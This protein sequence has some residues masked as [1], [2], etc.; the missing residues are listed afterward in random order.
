VNV[1]PAQW[2]YALACAALCASA[3]SACA[4]TAPATDAVVALA[5]PPP[6]PD[7]RVVPRTPAPPPLEE[8]TLP[9]GR[10]LPQG[11]WLGAMI[12]P[13]DVPTLAALG[14]RAV[15]SAVDPGEET[16]AALLAAG[17]SHYRIPLGSRFR[18]AETI[19]E[20]ASRY[21]ADEI[22]V[23]CRHGADRTGAIA[24]YLLVTR[25]DW[26]ISDALYA[27]VYP[28]DRD[29]EGLAEV[30]AEYGEVDPR[31]ARVVGDPDVGQFSLSGAGVGVGGMKVRNERYARLVTTVIEA[32]RAE[33]DV[34]AAP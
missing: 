31:G 15:V 25:H 5:P 22:Y 12:G 17:I 24:A 6:A 20:V 29:L 11:Y 7:V 2:K 13:K 30:L 1:R 19:D 34:A 23:H 26:S 18:Y 27:M 32:M 9:A 28:S 21:P 16:H 4:T 3:L 14:V 8:R 10:Q 33:L